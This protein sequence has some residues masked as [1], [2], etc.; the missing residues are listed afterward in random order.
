MRPSRSAPG[1]SDPKRCTATWLWYG[2][3][4]ANAPMR[5]GRWLEEHIPGAK[6]VIRKQTAHLGTL[7]AHWEDILVTLRD[8]G[9]PSR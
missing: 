1:T 8:A 3:L 5:N 2:E 6:L 9:E 4:D 7:I